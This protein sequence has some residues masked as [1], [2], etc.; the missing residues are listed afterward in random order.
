MEL[1]QEITHTNQRSF[2][3]DEQKNVT[4]ILTA[5]FPDIPCDHNQIYKLAKDFGNF[6]I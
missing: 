1:V 2:F 5:N 6:S 3:L 4:E